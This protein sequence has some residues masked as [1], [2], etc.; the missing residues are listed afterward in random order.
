MKRMGFLISFLAFFVIS[1][2]VT[3]VSSGKEQFYLKV[4]SLIEA[5]DIASAG[6]ML[7][8]DPDKDELRHLYLLGK[9]KFFSG[10]YTKAVELFNRSGVSDEDLFFKLARSS[11]KFTKNFKELKVA[12]FAVRV[13]P[14]KDEIL[15]P[16]LLSALESIM[17][18]VYEDLDYLP[19]EPVIVEVYSDLDAF[20]SVTPLSADSINKTG[21]VAICLYNRIILSSPRLYLRGYRWLDTVAHEYIH[22]AL[23]RLSGNNV[24]LW[25]QE[26]VAKYEESRWRSGKGGEMESSI[27]SVLRDSLASG[28]IVTLEEMGTSFAKLRSARRA[29]LAFAETASMIDYIISIGGLDMLKR[30]I[31]FFSEEMNEDEVFRRVL[32]SDRKAFFA[33]WQDHAKKIVK[34]AS[35]GMNIFHPLL[36]KDGEK[37]DLNPEDVPVEKAR[38]YLT[39]GDL[40]FARGRLDAAIAEYRKSNMVV[41]DSPYVLNKLALALIMKKNYREA[42]GYLQKSRELYPGFAPTMVHLSRVYLGL[43]DDSNLLQALL[44]ANAINPFDPYVHNQLYLLYKRTGDEPRVQIETRALELL[45]ME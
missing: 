21:T 1:A 40:L 43:G 41:S 26:G 25:L 20:S 33:S 2:P 13:H 34:D 22:Y 35:S 11:K 37:E 16:Y 9:I 36:K 28:D 44:E 7:K 27:K 18:A 45:K 17:R 12:N 4:N 19:S 24:P 42:L 29:A 5:W 30:V 6:D 15:V 23:A 38:D 39:L 32:N 14:G 8:K 3:G 31:N 10:E